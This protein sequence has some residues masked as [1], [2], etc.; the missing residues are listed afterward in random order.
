MPQRPLTPD[1]DSLPHA[2]YR[3]ERVRALDQA[4]IAEGVPAAELMERA[5]REAYRVLTE[6]WPGPR[7]ITVLCGGGNNAG[8]GYV[9]ARLA[10]ADRRAVRVLALRDPES[11]RGDALEM[12]KAFRDTGGVVEPFDR[13]APGTEVIVDALLGTGLE[14]EVTG[15]WAD[16]IRAV[17][18]HPGP[19]LAIDI[20]SGLDADTGAILG[21]AIQATATVTFIGLKPGLFTGNGPD[22]CGRIHFSALQVPARIYSRA[23]ADARR[24][25]WAARRAQLA[26]RQ[27]SAHKGHF[28]HVLIIG[29]AP[30]MAGAA[31]LAGEAALRTGAGLVTVATHPNHAPWLGLGR[32]EL[33]CRGIGDSRELHA[34]L[35]PAGVLAIGPGLSQQPWGRELWAAAIAQRMPLVVDADALNLLAASPQHRED[36]VLTPH[37]GEA[38]RLLGGSTRE[39][40][41]DRFAAV[42]ALRQRYG[43]VIVLKGAG[44]VID[45][46]TPRPPAVCSGGNPGMASGGTGDAL[47]GIIAALIAQGLDPE[48]AAEVGVCLHAAAGD[49]AAE[50]GERGLLASD[51]IAQLR[52]VLRQGGG[53]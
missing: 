11:L 38:A 3:A 40:Q 33:M 53:P 42:T 17:N 47:T 50:Q 9:L 23:L 49:A 35:E 13:L 36:W 8:D 43:G 27:R 25:D 32:P 4:A 24:I 5:G 29:G 6:L 20:P 41:H 51:L 1:T 26:P 39:V 31:R 19:V 52:P 12:A 15:R 16:A 34:L 14:R 48:E 21:E 18:G 2:L 10:L 37:P 30:G 46:P 44:T 22:C 45:G 7:A 28:G